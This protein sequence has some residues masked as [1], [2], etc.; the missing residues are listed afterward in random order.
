M[1]YPKKNRFF[2]E[3]REDFLT[4]G[5]I[6]ACLILL[7]F[8]PTNG[9]SQKITSMLVFLFILPLMYI[10]F[11]LKKNLAD[12][13]FSLKNPRAGFFWGGLMLLLSLAV[14]FL[15]IKF[16]G[17]KS[18]YALP[19]PVTGNFWLFLLYEL[20]AINLF[21]FLQEFFFKGFVLF[22]FLEK[23]SYWSVIFSALIYVGLLVATGGFS[24]QNSPFLILSLTGGVVAWKT[25]S[26]LYA[27][28]M[29][30]TFLI[31]FDAYLIS[32]LK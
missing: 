4:V 2:A 27:Y 13:G 1:V 10:K 30:L 16:S 19:A 21:F 3:H 18:A 28:F 31:F 12:F 20:L 32:I 25:R 23:F 11:I 22:S 6:L 9:L 5:L 24:W 17:L 26:F 15:L 7:V 14:A 8:F 29:G